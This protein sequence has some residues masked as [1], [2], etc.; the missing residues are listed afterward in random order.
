MWPIAD[1]ARF[2]VS[3]FAD[4]IGSTIG[5]LYDP[6]DQ[7][8]LGLGAFAHRWTWGAAWRGDVDLVHMGR[9]AVAGSGT[10][11]WTRISDDLQGQT[12]ASASA[13]GVGL[14]GEVRRS[15]AAGQTLGLIVR[16]QRLFDQRNASYRRVT[17]YATAALEWGWAGAPRP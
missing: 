15:V 17:Q 4:D 2:G 9:W 7:V 13:V 16:W 1:H 10:M 6:N 8:D 5:H 12:Y 11:G 14:G 3:L